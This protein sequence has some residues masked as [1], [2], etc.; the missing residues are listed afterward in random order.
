MTGKKKKFVIFSQ[1]R[2]GSTLLRL[3]LHAHSHIVCHGEVLSRQWINGLVPLDN[4][5]EERSSR[6]SV[7]ALL[8]MREK[9]PIDFLERYVWPFDSAAV[10]FK[11]VLEDFFKSEHK[12]RYQDY[13]GSEG[14]L[15]V[16]LYR[17]DQLANYASRVRMAKYNIKHEVSEAA[18]L[19]ESEHQKIDIALPTLERFVA[20]QKEYLSELRGLLRRPVL[21]TYEDLQDD[22][23]R[24]LARLGVADQSFTE[25]LVKTSPDD[26]SHV[27]QDYERLR[28]SGDFEIELS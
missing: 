20:E 9:D 8:P 14:V 4:P 17:R 11:L 6:E 27:V 23:P 1:A 22:Y 21:M 15:P 2:S 12:A 19:A 16:I 26:L 24:L 18:A 5:V 25:K 10:G 13:L 28:Q 7:E 3:S